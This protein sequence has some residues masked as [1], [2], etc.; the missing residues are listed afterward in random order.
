M[1][2]LGVSSAAAKDDRSKSSFASWTSSGRAEII[3]LAL[4]LAVLPY[5]WLTLVNAG[6][7]SLKPTHLLIPLVALISVVRLNFRLRPLDTLSLA[8][9]AV[10]GVRLLFDATSLLW[11][12]DPAFGLIEMLRQS[13]NFAL[14]LLLL[15]AVR[16]MTTQELSRAVTLGAV[17]QIV[18]TT[19]VFFLVLALAGQNPVT[20]VLGSVAKGDFRELKQSLFLG[21]LKA[22]GVA[23]SLVNQRE[24]SGNDANAFGSGLVLTVLFAVAL[25]GYAAKPVSKTFLALAIA[26]A[27]FYVL[28]SRSD[29][30]NVFVIMVL[31][32]WGGLA[33][34]RAWMGRLR[35]RHVLVL[36]ALLAVTALAPVTLWIQRDAVSTAYTSLVDDPRFTDLGRILPYVNDAPAYGLGFGTPTGGASGAVDVAN[37]YPHNLW[38]YDLVSHGVF[39]I[40]TAGLWFGVLTAGAVLAIVRSMAATTRAAAWRFR[41]AALGIGYAVMTTQVA[42]MGQLFLTAWIALVLGLVCTESRGETSVPGR[43]NERGLPLAPNPVENIAR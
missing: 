25:R 26:H 6:G 7:L 18:A 40:L 1:T 35:G 28:I 38:L 4:V 8:L 2:P 9:V 22:L 3:L 43:S 16:Q 37:W 20:L 31:M 19:G 30:V 12:P 24:V 29:R 39:G 34:L 14:G 23:G 27:A 33:V 42:S 17:L 10:Y 5:P 15:V 11:S 13:V 32:L 36:A 41:G 21:A